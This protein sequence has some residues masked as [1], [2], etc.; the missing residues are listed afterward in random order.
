MSWVLSER[1]KVNGPRLIEESV[2]NR[3]IIKGRRYV[4]KELQPKKTK[5]YWMY[6]IDGR[7]TEIE[8]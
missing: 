8:K 6:T 5:I 3:R 2:K 1:E 4:F 7:R